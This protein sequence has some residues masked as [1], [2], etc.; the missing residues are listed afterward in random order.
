MSRASLISKISNSS[1]QI[2]EIHDMNFDHVPVLHLIANKGFNPFIY[3]DN[4]GVLPLKVQTGWSC[5]D[6]EEIA[7]NHYEI[8]QSDATVGAVQ[9]FIKLNSP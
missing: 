2:R 6:I 8:L 4:D 7:A 5:G 3:E 1:R 9:N